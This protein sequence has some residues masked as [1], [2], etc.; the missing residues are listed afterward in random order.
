MMPTPR[1]ASEIAIRVRM[2]TRSRMRSQ[3]PRAA[4]KGAVAWMNRTLATVVSYSAVMNEIIAAAK[5]TAMPRLGQSKRL[6][7]ARQS[8]CSLTAI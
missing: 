5:V 3:A 1:S 4:K 6:T 2:S 7:T 8:P